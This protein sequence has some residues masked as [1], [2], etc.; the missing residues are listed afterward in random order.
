MGVAGLP[1]LKMLMTK[2][3]MLCEASQKFSVEF[4]QLGPVKY[5][6]TLLKVGL[7]S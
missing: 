3:S 5:V 1:I 7:D 2:S 6:H 4:V